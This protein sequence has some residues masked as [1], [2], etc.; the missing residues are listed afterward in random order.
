MRAV[1]FLLLCLLSLPALSA[2]S[3]DSL[4]NV[5]ATARGDKKVK[6]LN[7]LFRAYINSDPVK[8]IGYSRE[9]L[10]LATEIDDQKGIAASYNNL[11]VAY[12]NQG[13]L[14]KSLEYYLTALNIYTTLGN[15]EG[16]A[17]TKNNIGT[18][19]S[20]K[21]DYGQAMKYFEESQKL[22]SDLNDKGRL[23][24]TMNNLGNLHSDLQLYEQAL[25]FYSEAWQMSEKM[26]QPFGDPLSNIGN[27]YFR[28]GNY[29]RAV[30][31]YERAL[32]LAKKQN[33]NLNILNITANLG[34]VY[35]KAGRTREAENYLEQANALSKQ[36]QATFFEPQ[37]LRSLANNYAKQG[38]MKEAFET[39]VAYDKVKEKVYGEE[40]TRKIA[41]MEM[42]LDLQERE[43]E[44]EGLRKDD[45]IKTLELNNTRMV[46]TVVV[47]GIIML[48]A[49]FN[50]F[51]TRKWSFIKVKKS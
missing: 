27:L 35:V 51:Y 36:M 2:G 11:G 9:A 49:G 10:N 40:S 48:V 14:D 43:E 19:H 17:T 38:K 42:A 12:K 16:I 13:A 20:L 37:I 29:Q 21:K 24:S 30:E 1:I 47:L 15:V 33:N 5:L 7:E 44:V 8:A 23:I 45:E 26:G 3:V 34:E 31:Y 28:Q 39:M 4:E 6:T 25:K 46:I 22:L 50:L 41:Q 32:E 18:I